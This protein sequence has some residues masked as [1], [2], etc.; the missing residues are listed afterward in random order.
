MQRK[1][2]PTADHVTGLQDAWARERPDIDT[3]GMAVLGRARRITLL[4]RGPIEAVLERFGCDSGEFDVLATL[5]RAGAPYCLRPTEL[6]GSL[7]ISSG[8]LTDRLAR[9]AK[10]GLVARRP[11]NEDKRSLTVE[12]T[13][14]GLELV[15]GAFAADMRVEKELISGLSGGERK[16][17]ALLLSKLALVVEDRLR[18]PAGG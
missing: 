7:M 5:R 15:D 1:G 2:A 17:L 10:R 4:A 18:R 16:M 14:K 13:R 6:Y 11:S 12:L 9:L 3:E 8:G